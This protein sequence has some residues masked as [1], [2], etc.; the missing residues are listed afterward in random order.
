MDPSRT[1]ISRQEKIEPGRACKECKRLVLCEYL[2]SS[3]VKI[4]RIPLA[5]TAK[6]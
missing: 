3:K 1:D 2:L 4:D 6:F 5:D